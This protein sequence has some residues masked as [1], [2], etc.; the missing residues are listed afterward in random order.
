[1]SG[2]PVSALILT[3][4]EEKKIA[5]CLESLAWADE[6]IVVDALSTD[7]TKE[8]CLDK[9]AP[10]AAKLR[11]LE[12]PWSGFR[13][14]RNFSLQ[15]AGHEWVLV[16]DADE[17]CT[18]E[19]ASRIQGLLDGTHRRENDA[20]KIHR[21]EFFQGKPIFY[22]MWNPSYQDRFFKKTGVAYINEIHEYPVFKQPPGMIHESLLHQSDL[23][24]ERY[25]EK[26][27][28]YTTI[29]ARDRYDQGQRTNAFKLVGAFPAH[30]FKSFFYYMA[31]K[32]G[33][34]GLVISLLEGV[35]RVVRQIKIWQI[36]QAGRK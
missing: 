22:G 15:Q 27:N 13:D 6:I 9:N 28:R 3:Y 1:M 31:Y 34:H 25:L 19:L 2:E 32:D 12:R 7:R 33:I 8:I 29:E 14:Q 26:L 4:N 36:Q 10:W 35:S 18:P 30:A 23:T 24:V 21:R 20:Y 17:R 16:V 11:W 5:G